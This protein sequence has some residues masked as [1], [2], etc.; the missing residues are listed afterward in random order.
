MTILRRVGQVNE[1][2]SPL[3]G[4]PLVIL[5]SPIFRTLSVS[6]MSRYT[7]IIPPPTPLCCR[8]P[9]A[10]ARTLDKLPSKIKKDFVC[11]PND[12]GV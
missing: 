1:A 5:V 2:T 12:F 11:E 10:S 4:I 6:L 8:Y 7:V 9:P 3:E